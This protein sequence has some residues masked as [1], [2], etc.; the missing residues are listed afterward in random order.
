MDFI[1]PKKLQIII[2]SDDKQIMA[3]YFNLFLNYCNNA[4]AK[5]ESCNDCPIYDICPIDFDTT[6]T[7]NEFVNFICNQIRASE[8]YGV[9][10][11]IEEE[12]EEEGKELFALSLEELSKIYPVKKGD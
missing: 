6:R 12:E 3:D 7:A 8:E 2:G 5:T 1:Q 9:M 11:E 4:Q 10:E